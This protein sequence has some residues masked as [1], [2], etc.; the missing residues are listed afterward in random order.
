MTAATQASWWHWVK[1]CKIVNGLQNCKWMAKLYTYVYPIIWYAVRA[2]ERERER[3]SE[4]ERARRHF[5]FAIHSYTSFPGFFW[6]GGGDEGIVWL[7]FI[8]PKECLRLESEPGIFWFSFIFSSLFP[9]TDSAA[10]HIDRQGWLKNLGRANCDSDFRQS[11]IQIL[12]LGMDKR[13]QLW[14]PG[15][16]KSL[17]ILSLCLFG[18]VTL[19]TKAQN[20][21]I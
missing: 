7:S 18:V 14:H 15:S 11:P 10:I 8:Q 16:L 4:S 6:G 3:E 1:N 2:R 17:K 5:F 20:R 19:V 21:F 9:S 12:L 13:S